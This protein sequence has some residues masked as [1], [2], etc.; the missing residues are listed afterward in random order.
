MFFKL[1]SV[2][3]YLK[4]IKRSAITAKKYLIKKSKNVPKDHDPD[5]HKKINHIRSAI[6][7]FIEPVL[8]NGTY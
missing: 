1:L 3:C 5:L 2:F 8:S 4:K 6:K 7:K